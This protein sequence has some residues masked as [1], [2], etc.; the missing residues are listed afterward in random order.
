MKSLPSRRYALAVLAAG[1]LLSGPAFALDGNAFLAALGQRYEASGGK[2]TAG[3]V[4]VDGSTII[5]KSARLEMT[6]PQSP[7]VVL[8]LGDVT[9]EN[10]EDLGNGGYR[11]AHMTM[12]ELIFSQDK[13]AFNLKD[14]KTDGMEIPPMGNDWTSTTIFYDKTTT[15]PMTISM[16]GKTILS[17]AGS[18]AAMKRTDGGRGMFFDFTVDGM[19][20]EPATF[21]DPAS[22]PTIQA[23]GIET[24]DAKAALSGQWDAESGV[25]TLNRY[26]IDAANIGTLKMEFAMTGYTGALHKTVQDTQ[27]AMRDNP[28]QQAGAQAAG[29]AMLGIAQQINIG[30]ILLRFEDAGITGRTLDYFGKSQGVSGEQFAGAIKGMVPMMLAQQGIQDPDN[31][32]ST[33]VGNFLEKPKNISIA[34]KPSQPTPVMSLVGTIS[35]SPAS[36]LSLPGLSITAND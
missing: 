15:G 26:D 10:V 6:S 25:F 7:S 24:I 12:P 20:M 4:T 14:V 31:R 21:A 34:F 29:L 9:F 17:V 13:T 18:Q 27:K 5:A 19:H 36:I 23:L 33:A 3:E 8:S 28:D 2:L 30:N 35:A 32:L 11:V 16:D 1:T 22:L